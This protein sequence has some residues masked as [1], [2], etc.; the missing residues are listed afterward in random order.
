[1]DETRF[2]HLKMIFGAIAAWIANLMDNHHFTLADWA[3][4]LAILYSAMQIGL[5]LPKYWR[6]TKVFFGK[7]VGWLK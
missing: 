1:M 7:I 2:P 5:L 3:T 6:L 4:I